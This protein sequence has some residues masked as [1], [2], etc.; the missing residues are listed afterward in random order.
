LDDAKQF[1]QVAF[2]RENYLLDA[3]SDIFW[4]V[5]EDGY[6]IFKRNDSRHFD[7]PR[8]KEGGLD[9]VVMAACFDPKHVG[10]VDPEAYAMRL[11]DLMDDAEER[12]D[13]RFVKLAHKEIFDSFNSDPTALGY[14]IGLEGGEPF[15]GDMK[16]FDRF[17]ERGMRLLC[18]TH[19]ANNEISQGVDETQGPYYVTGFGWEVIA[20]CEERGV[21]VDIAH[22]NEQCVKFILD[23]ATKPFV[24]S[25]T[26][27]RALC[28]HRRNILDDHL[29]ELGR[30]GCVVGID[31]IQP[32]LKPG[33]DYMNATIDDVLDHIEHAI[34]VAGINSVGLG[35]DMDIIYPLPGGLTDAT[36]YPVIADGLHRRGW[37]DGDIA[38]VMGGNFRRVFSQV[39]PPSI[40]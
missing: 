24:V 29:F 33:P 5:D 9:V 3:H 13:G 21:I 15:K 7:V 19:N 37:E 26:A 20:A 14:I 38:K 32:H 10:D 12:S 17:Y 30:L 16:L 6:D 4:R 31:L 27:C 34:E 23:M 8:A 22:L 1:G 25:H 18:L 35:T 2:C 39:L 40:S 11:I 36:S 28:D